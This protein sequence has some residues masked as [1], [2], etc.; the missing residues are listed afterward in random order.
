MAVPESEISEITDLEY[1]LGKIT[2]VIV[3]L[4][5]APILH[6]TARLRNMD[7]ANQSVWFQGKHP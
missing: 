1:I 2:A 4:S 7:A 6:L 3:T 5:A